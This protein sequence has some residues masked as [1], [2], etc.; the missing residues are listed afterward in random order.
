MFLGCLP[1]CSPCLQSLGATAAI[2]QL[3][4]TNTSYCLAYSAGI[5]NFD[6]LAAN[7]FFRGEEI[8]SGSHVL[9]FVSEDSEKVYLQ[10]AVLEGIEGTASCQNNAR[11]VGEVYKSPTTLTTSPV[12]FTNVSNSVVLAKFYVPFVVTT[13][14]FPPTAYP[15]GEGVGSCSRPIPTPICSPLSASGYRSKVS[16]GTVWAVCLPAPFASDA[17]YVYA[18]EFLPLFTDPPTGQ[19]FGI[20][21]TP[22]FRQ[23]IASNWWNFVGNEQNRPSVLGVSFP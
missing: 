6:F 20:P 21:G 15:P 2:L 14:F 7:T 4:A 9:D 10:S 16:I 23:L 19:D 3:A 5:F 11:I 13:H 12:G 18:T 17:P 1:C 22:V 8:Y